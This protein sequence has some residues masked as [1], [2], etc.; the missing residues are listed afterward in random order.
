MIFAGKA[1]SNVFT[2]AVDAADDR[3]I[4]GIPFETKITT[5]P[6]GSIAC[7][8]VIEGLFDSIDFAAQAGALRSI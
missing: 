3:E 6:E 1:G 8:L 7:Q 5:Q 4:L 2:I